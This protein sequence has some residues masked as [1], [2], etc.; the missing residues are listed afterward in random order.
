MFSFTGYCV[1]WL[2]CDKKWFEFITNSQCPFRV[3]YKLIQTL[4]VLGM[5]TNHQSLHPIWRRLTLLPIQR[6]CHLPI[7]AR[8]WNGTF[9]SWTQTGVIWDGCWSCGGQFRG[10]ALY[11]FEGEEVFF[12]LWVG[13]WRRIC[14]VEWGW[15]SCERRGTNTKASLSEWIGWNPMR[16]GA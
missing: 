16:Q 7:C 3:L 14:F 6:K 4:F 13:I 5:K 8:L 2:F 10:V 9:R 1:W 11:I 15:S 12:C